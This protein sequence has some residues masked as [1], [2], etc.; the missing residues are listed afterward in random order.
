[1]LVW[2][3]IKKQ[4]ALAL[5]IF[6]VFLLS[7]VPESNCN[8]HNPSLESSLELSGHGG[9]KEVSRAGQSN[10]VVSLMC[11]RLVFALNFPVRLV[12]K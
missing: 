7:V 3:H 12:V 5:M 10:P 6:G 8:T 11:W 1:M 4:L 9:H 2:R